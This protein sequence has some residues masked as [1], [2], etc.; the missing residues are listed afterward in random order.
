MTERTQ[1]LTSGE[2][3]THRMTVIECSCKVCAINAQ[4]LGKTL[5]LRAEIT[6]ALA[7][8]TTTRKAIHAVIDMA[9]D[10][11]ISGGNP[12]IVAL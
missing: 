8:R 5:P 10:P 6:E 1:T 12:W 2:T 4:H 11:A 9:H 7:A 3:I